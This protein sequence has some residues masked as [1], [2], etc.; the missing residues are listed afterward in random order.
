[1]SYMPYSRIMYVMDTSGQQVSDSIER[2][3][4]I[5]KLAG[6]DRS[7]KPYLNQVPTIDFLLSESYISEFSRKPSITAVQ[8]IRIKNKPV[9]FVAV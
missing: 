1:M 2:D 3:G 8:I 7:E 6:L 9:G 4:D 5:I